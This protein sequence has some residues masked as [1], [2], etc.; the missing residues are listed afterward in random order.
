MTS[1]KNILFF[2]F[3]LSA[4]FIGV[5]SAFAKIE[6]ILVANDNILSLNEPA[7]VKM[8]F[9][10][11]DIGSWANYG[12]HA[13]RY[14]AIL[15]VSKITTDPAQ[16]IKATFNIDRVSN[17]W[18][19]NNNYLLQRVLE[20]WNPSTVAWGNQPKLDSSAI[21][22]QTA[23]DSI[24]K[25]DITETVKDWL[26]NPSG[27][28][29]ILIKKNVEDTSFTHNLGSFACANYPVNGA[30]DRPT[31]TIESCMED[32]WTCGKWSAC[33]ENGEQTRV[34]TKSLDCP[35]VDTPEKPETSQSCTPPPP[36]CTEDI[37]DCEDWS[38]CSISGSQSR[39]CTLTFDCSAVS[40][41]SP[42]VSQNCTAPKPP[43]PALPQSPESPAPKETCS[44]DTWTC[45]DWGACSLSGVQGRSCSR[46][47]DC[48]NA[49]T[50][51]PPT[52]QYCESQNKPQPVTPNNP[53]AA[54]NQDTIIK[55]TVKLICPLDEKKA[56]Q[57]SGTIIDQD[58]T[59]L[60][61]KHVIQGTAGCWVGFIDSYND[62]PYFDAAQIAD[63]TRVSQSEDIALLKLKNPK[64]KKLV[65][66]DINA[67]SNAA[68]NLGTRIT[69]YGYPAKFGTTM[70]YTSGDFSGMNGS[71]VKTSAII[72]HGNSGGGAYL[73]DGAFVGMP[74]AVIKGELNALGYI[75]S[76]KNIQAWL[77]NK[78]IA[79]SP[80]TTNNYARVKS[81][82]EQTSIKKL[83]S[84]ALSIPGENTDPL[85][86]KKAP[87]DK[88]TPEAP[89]DTAAPAKQAPEQLEKQTTDAMT[90]VEPK[91]KFS[92]PATEV[93][94]SWFQRALRWIGNIFKK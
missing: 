3:V 28:Y 23:P 85:P 29:G 42:A 64:K 70:T 38:A 37:W 2:I 11:G 21:S 57:G 44:A 59:I 17:T 24:F 62:E 83:P 16:I 31:I 47:F 40:S 63:I 73:A 60:T 19:D 27:N 30:E 18:D 15:D 34:C 6:T 1:Y 50:A 74:T 22:P 53:V 12:G 77:N 46:T 66:V 35:N 84:F 48:P 81:I 71:Y 4:F 72:E 36:A 76:I 58:G 91:Q 68:L 86:I 39:S 51:P 93:K 89:S 5:P 54:A 75:I 13:Y 78:T 65:S 7:K 32:V 80:G 92:A 20:P 26:K 41:P 94:Q 43:A 52:D 45:D 79:F 90:Y 88:K 55:A 14:I 67:G 10:Y 87:E 9:T 25:F 8:C 56:S 49:V 82:L 69:I 61:N 33:G